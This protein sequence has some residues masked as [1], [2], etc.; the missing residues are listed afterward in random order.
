MC[1]TCMVGYSNAVA[2]TGKYSC[3][4]DPLSGGAIAGIVIGVLA[5]L[6]I[7]GGLA[8]YFICKNKR[9]KAGSN[10]IEAQSDVLQPGS[11]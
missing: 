7:A 1:A 3:E 8:A 4:K 5:V 9:V 11:A 6:G 10:I 2:S